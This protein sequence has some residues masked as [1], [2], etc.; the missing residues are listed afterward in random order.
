MK[1][2]TLKNN[3]DFVRAYRKGKSYVSYGLVTYV[4]KNKNCNLRVGLTTSKKVGNAVSR[5]RCRRIIRAAFYDIC[6]EFHVD[7]H[8]NVDIVFVAR[9]KTSFLKST[10]VKRLMLSH[11]KESGVLKADEKTL[12][13]NEKI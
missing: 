9:T 5:S 13:P 3:R 10:D 11:L 6:G 4:I 2:Q 1:L 8:Q 12:R 7:M